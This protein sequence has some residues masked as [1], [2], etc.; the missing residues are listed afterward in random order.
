MLYNSDQCHVD[1]VMLHAQSISSRCIFDTYLDFLPTSIYHYYTR[2]H[3]IDMKKMDTSNGKKGVMLLY[4]MCT[5][6]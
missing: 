6:Y 5:D 2:V 3:V 1:T 4:R